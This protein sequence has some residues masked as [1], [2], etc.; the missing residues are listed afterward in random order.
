VTYSSAK[1]LYDECTY[2]ELLD[3]A[4]DCQAVQNRVRAQRG[5]EEAINVESQ[6][7]NSY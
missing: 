5:K 7:I 3:W 4:E 2:A 1:A 6:I